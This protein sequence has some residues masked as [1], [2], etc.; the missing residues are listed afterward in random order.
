MG[1][2]GFRFQVGG[3]WGR[4]DGRGGDSV[5]IRVG[6]RTGA[7]RSWSLLACGA[8]ISSINK[9]AW[10]GLG[11][12]ERL[13]ADVMPAAS[14]YPAIRCRQ[15]RPRLRLRPPYLLPRCLCASI[16]VRGGGV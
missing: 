15:A 8:S 3:L 11:S 5:D 4:I 16:V 1:R 9:G 13:V 7:C 2:G 10:L 14:T 12:R 6:M